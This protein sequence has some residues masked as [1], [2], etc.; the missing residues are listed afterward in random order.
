MPPD[1]PLL[2]GELASLG[3]NLLKQAKWSEAEPVLRECLAIREK[4]IPDEWRRFNA[5]S[6]LGEAI[7][8]CGSIRRS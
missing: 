3:S 2:A 4:A 6:M 8:G 1:S 7:L 5:M